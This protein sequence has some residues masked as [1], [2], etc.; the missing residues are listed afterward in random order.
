MKY[1]RLIKLMIFHQKLCTYIHYLNCNLG[2]SF[3]YRKIH[4]QNSNNSLINFYFR[5]LIPHCNHHKLHTILLNYYNIFFNLK[6]HKV[7]LH[8][9]YCKILIKVLSNYKKL[10]YHKNNFN[11]LMKYKMKHLYD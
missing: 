9:K 10:H 4:Y 3:I 2:H 1:N 7:K 8:F 11:Y 5:N 6:F